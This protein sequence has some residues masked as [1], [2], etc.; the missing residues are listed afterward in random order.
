MLP[1]IKILASSQKNHFLGSSEVPFNLWRHTPKVASQ[2]LKNI[3]SIYFLYLLL[4]ANNKAERHNVVAASLFF[5]TYNILDFVAF[6][7]L[8]YKLNK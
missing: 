8:H 7:I 3:I 6:I 1:V 5:N 4:Q 2:F